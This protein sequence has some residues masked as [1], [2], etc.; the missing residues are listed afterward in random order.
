MSDYIL[1]KESPSIP[2]NMARTVSRPPH[3]PPLSKKKP[4]THLLRVSWAYRHSPMPD[5]GHVK[6]GAGGG[7]PEITVSIQ[8][9]GPS[10]RSGVPYEGQLSSLPQVQKA[11][12]RNSALPRSPRPPPPP[13]FSFLHQPQ[14]PPLHGQQPPTS[15]AS[16]W[17]LTRPL[18]PM[19]TFCPR[20]EAGYPMFPLAEPFLGAVPPPTHCHHLPSLTVIL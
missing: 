20:P 7:K 15:Q 14:L 16:P 19:H 17:L 2:K 13:R 5:D 10:S 12:S 1:E 9:P 4:Y 3:T 8:S 6:E 18:W 11:T